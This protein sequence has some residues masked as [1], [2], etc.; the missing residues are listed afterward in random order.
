MQAAKPEERAGELQ[1]P[2]EVRALLI[3]ADEQR[4]ALGEPRQRPLHQRAAVGLCLWSAGEQ[5]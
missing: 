3:I 4:P 1:Q 5:A 2:Q